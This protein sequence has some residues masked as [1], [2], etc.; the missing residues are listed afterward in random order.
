MQ[1]AALEGSSHM[2]SAAAME[3]CEPPPASV[4]L[5]IRGEAD[6][7]QVCPVPSIQNVRSAALKM[8]GEISRERPAI[9]ETR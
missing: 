5:S 7:E 9:A 3:H 4:T 2:G 6:R 1:A 8:A